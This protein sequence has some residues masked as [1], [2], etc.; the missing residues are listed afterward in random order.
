M[1]VSINAHLRPV[2][3][4]RAQ[5]SR[6]TVVL[7]TPEGPT[8]HNTGTLGQGTSMN[9]VVEAQHRC[10]ISGVTVS[11]SPVA[12]RGVGERGQLGSPQEKERS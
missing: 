7:P 11:D 4:R 12:V 6:P 3:P 1:S 8:S 5:I 10:F 9:I 2:S